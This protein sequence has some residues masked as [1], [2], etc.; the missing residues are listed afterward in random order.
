MEPKNAGWP[1][2]LMGIKELHAEA[3][4]CRSWA[5]AQKRPTPT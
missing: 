5:R 4:A 2:S 3:K 1:A